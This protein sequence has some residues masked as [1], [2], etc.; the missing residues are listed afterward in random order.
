MA[1]CRLHSHGMTCCHAHKKPNEAGL[2]VACLRGLAAASLSAQH[3]D[4]VLC[5]GLHDFLLHACDGQA[6]S[7][8]HHLPNKMV[9]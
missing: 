9:T 8:C 1:N 2:R 3:H 7:C 6:L 4:V 5:N